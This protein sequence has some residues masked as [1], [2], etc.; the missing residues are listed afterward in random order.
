[1]NSITWKF[2]IE[3]PNYSSGMKNN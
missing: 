1:M 2:K 3:L